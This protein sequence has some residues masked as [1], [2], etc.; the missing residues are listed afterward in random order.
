MQQFATNIDNDTEDKSASLYYKNKYRIPSARK[1]DHDYAGG[2]YF[3]TICSKNREWSFGHIEED[4][5]GTK[6]MIL[7]DIGNYA[8]QMIQNLPLHHPYASVPLWVVMPNHVHLIVIIDDDKTPYQRRNSVETRHATSLQLREIANMQGWLSVTVGGF[9]SAVTKYAGTNNIHFAWQTRFHDHIIRNQAEMN[10]IAEYIENNVAQW[11]D[12]CFNGN[13]T[14]AVPRP[15]GVPDN[16]TVPCA[17]ALPRIDTEPYSDAPPRR[18]AAC[19][20]STNE[21]RNITE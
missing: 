6:R 3:V 20:V 11:D 14:D 10:R 21:P 16:D 17:D 12:D 13:R 2:A 1:T 19:H 5:N 18:D 8:E 7:N 4:S 15:D 9:K